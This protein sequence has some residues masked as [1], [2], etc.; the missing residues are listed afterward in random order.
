M[1][2]HTAICIIA[3][4]VYNAHVSFRSCF[5][6][7]HVVLCLKCMTGMCSF[8]VWANFCSSLQ[9]FASCKRVME[10]SC[11]CCKYISFERICMFTGMYICMSMHMVYMCMYTC[12]ACMHAACNKV[13]HTFLEQGVATVTLTGHGF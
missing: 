6:L 13:F 12:D 1:R 8:F 9:F 5:T 4:N 3:A 10:P 2:G 7:I 11:P